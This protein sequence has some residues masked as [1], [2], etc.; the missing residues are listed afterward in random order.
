[1]DDEIGGITLI[2]FLFG[3]A[4]SSGGSKTSV[5]LQNLGS[6]AYAAVCGFLRGEFRLL[7]RCSHAREIAFHFHNW[8]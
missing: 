2:F 5:F 4:R 6:D 1:M 8:L 7:Q 3:R